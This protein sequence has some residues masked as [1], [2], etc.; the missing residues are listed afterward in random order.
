MTCEDDTDGATFDLSNPVTRGDSLSG[1]GFLWL[2]ITGKCNL[3][4]VHCYAD[5]SP[6]GSLY[7][8]MSVA[9]WIHVI[10]DAAAAGCRQ[11]QF[12]GGEPTLHPGLDTMIRHA[13]ELNFDLV[14]VYT[15]ATALTERRL[16]FFQEM[17]VSIATSFYSFN[18]RTHETITKGPG[19]FAKTVTGIE[20]AARK[21]IPMRIGLVHMRG[22]NDDDRPATIAFLHGLGATNIGEDWVRD[23][24]RGSKHINFD[25]HSD[26]YFGALCGQCW[27]GLL[28]VTPDG[29]AYPCVFS[30]KSCVGNVLERGLTDILESRGLI[31]TRDLIRRKTQREAIATRRCHPE[32]VT[33]ARCHPEG[34]TAAR[35]HPE[36]VMEARCHPE[37]V[38]AARC[39]PEGVT[40][41]RCHPEGVMA[42]RCHPEGVMEARCHPEGVAVARCHPEGVTVARCH[43]EGVMAAR[44]HPEGVMEARCHPEGVAVAR[45]HPEGVT[46]LCAPSAW[47]DI[48]AT[49][50]HPTYAKPGAGTVHDEAM[51]GS[52]ED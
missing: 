34:V 17:G 52:A 44:C 8:E 24:G 47:N 2:E 11:L 36:G 42:A 28:C 26:A 27:K 43:P 5:S 46:A 22:I 51:V 25:G 14:E 38:A 48:E 20:A 23:V 6:A 40:V 9:D 4:C 33:V 31:R 29:S 50:C 13:R 45:C 16:A 35:C 1:I 32:G 41:A 7:G 21:G 37:G 39:H 10:D 3:E 19:S 30:R 49:A 15:N 12:I 18:A